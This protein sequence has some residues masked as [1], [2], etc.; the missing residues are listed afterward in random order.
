[1]ENPLSNLLNIT[2]PVIQEIKSA[3]EIVNELVEDTKES[4]TNLNEKIPWTL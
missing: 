3:E 4:V 2:Y 1:M